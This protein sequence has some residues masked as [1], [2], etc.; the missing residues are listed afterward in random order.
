[1]VFQKKLNYPFKNVP[2]KNKIQILLL[3]QILLTSKPNIFL[4]KIFFLLFLFMLC[5]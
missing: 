5:N 3:L 4:F 2:E 1:M